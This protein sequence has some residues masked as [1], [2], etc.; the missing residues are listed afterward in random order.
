MTTTQSNQN[1]ASKALAEM[2][3]SNIDYIQRLKE[4]ISLNQLAQ[5][6]AET[7]VGIELIGKPKYLASLYSTNHHALQHWLDDLEQW[8]ATIDT[9][10]PQHAETTACCVYDD[11]EFYRDHANDLKNIAVMAC[12][13]VDELKRRNPSHDFRLL[14]HLTSVIKRLAVNFLSD[15]E[16]EL[17]VLS[18]LYPDLFMAEV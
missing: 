10:E 9:T 6:Q 4:I 15:L 16:A 12:D 5:M 7:L 2:Y 18:Q 13:Q 3:N 1:Q 11:Y 17:D 8:Q 14:D